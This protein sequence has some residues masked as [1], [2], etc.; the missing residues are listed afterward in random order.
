MFEVKELKALE[1]HFYL[2]IHKPEGLLMEYSKGSFHTSFFWAIEGQNNESYRGV[3]SSKK[4]EKFPLFEKFPTE[5]GG[6]DR[7]EWFPYFYR[8]LVMKA[9]LSSMCS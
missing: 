6:L 7:L 5:G 9:N 2:V 3:G 4:E 8:F 1:Y